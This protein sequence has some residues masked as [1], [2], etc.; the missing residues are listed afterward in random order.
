MYT[1]FSKPGLESE[2]PPL[3]GPIPQCTH[4]SDNLG[5]FG[6]GKGHFGPFWAILRPI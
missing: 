6:L 5:N 1:F 3:S 4:S 2:Y